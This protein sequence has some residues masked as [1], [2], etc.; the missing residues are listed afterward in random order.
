VPEALSSCSGGNEPDDQGPK[1]TRHKAS[2]Y[3]RGGF[4]A[5]CANVLTR[6]D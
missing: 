2:V 1:C 3:I 6:C 4:S 5:I